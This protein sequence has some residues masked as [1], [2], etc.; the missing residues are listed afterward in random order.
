MALPAIHDTGVVSKKKNC[1]LL[2][3]QRSNLAREASDQ[4]CHLPRPEAVFRRAYSAALRFAVVLTKAPNG[5]RR[6]T[7][8]QRLMPDC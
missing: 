5:I 3:L 1:H 8:I 2:K 7:D 6:A 4:A